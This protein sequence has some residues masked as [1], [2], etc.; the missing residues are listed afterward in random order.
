VDPDAPTEPWFFLPRWADPTDGAQQPS[1]QA[2]GSVVAKATLS[3]MSFATPFAP[4]GKTITLPGRRKLTLLRG[5]GRGSAATA[6]RAI[7][8]TDA[9]VRRPVVVKIFDLSSSDEL[10]GAAL[11][12]GRAAQRAGYVVHPNAV[13]T[14]EMAVIGRSHAAV[15]TEFV[16]GTTLEQLVRGQARAGEA[17]DGSR[18]VALDL[19][20]FITTE[21]AEALSGARMAVTPE[22]VHAGMPHLDVSLHQVLLSFHGEVKLS[23]FGLAQV[24]LFGSR[25]RTIRT[26]SERWASVAPEVAQGKPG[27]ARSDVFSLGILL[28]EMLIGPR[29]ASGLSDAEAVEHTREGFVPPTFHELQLPPAVSG[30]MRR[31]LERN[32]SR[33]Y[34]HA[35]AMAYELRR[36]A[37]SMGVGDGRVFLRNAISE[38]MAMAATPALGSAAMPVI[39]PPHFEHDSET[40]EIEIPDSEPAR[41]TEDRAS[42][43]VLKV[44]RGRKTSRRGGE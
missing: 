25:V 41:P 17:G 32:P 31:A 23:D 26:I 29:F 27:D 14:Y 2:I 33:R 6:Y 35:T 13:Q 15:V 28:R 5:L 18:R 34:S 1:L 22:G 24:S 36:V 16:E 38:Q 20:L 44:G 19:A 4:L 3:P 39:E 40:V 8:E 10:E 43:L 21:I 11:A 12:L 37:L 30:I 42:G 9:F 7:L